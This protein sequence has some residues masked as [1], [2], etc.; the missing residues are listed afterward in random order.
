MSYKTILAHLHKGARAPFILEAAANLGEQYQAHVI[1]LHTSFE[2]VLI[3]AGAGFEMPGSAL[4]QFAK[5]ER[6]EGEGVY[7]TFN[8]VAEKKQAATFEWRRVAADTIDY[9][10]DEVVNQARHCDIAITDGKTHTDP[11]TAWSD[12]PVRL[13]MEGG[14]PVVLVPSSGLAATLGQRVLIA[15]N[16]KR[17]AARA[18]FDALP[19]LK[20]AQTV[21]VLSV[22]SG[23]KSL[24]AS[25]DQLTKTLVRHGVKAQ[26]KLMESS[27]KSDARMVM[28]TAE[29]LNCDLLVMGCYGHSR[30]RQM[31]F[32]GV[33]Q[34]V[35]ANLDIP[36]LTSH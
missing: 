27:E 12:M 11:M 26:V 33:T 24:A 18:A 23:D 36:V 28:A 16:G 34:F 6:E 15:W 4:E 22:T 31:L 9:L 21:T 20:R 30:F 2:N 29:D 8:A 1:A 7:A 14:R 3:G 25:A 35:L 32:G 17:E 10:F 19:I 5:K 13:I